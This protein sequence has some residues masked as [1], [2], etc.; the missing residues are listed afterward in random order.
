MKFTADILSKFLNIHPQDNILGFGIKGLNFALHFCLIAKTYGLCL[1]SN[2]KNRP[3]NPFVYLLVSVFLLASAAIIDIASINNYNQ[4]FRYIF[5]MIFFFPSFYI[6]STMFLNKKFPNKKEI[7]KI[8]FFVF[9]LGI[10][11]H[12]NIITF[13]GFL[14][15]IFIYSVF[16]NRNNLSL[17]FKNLFS[18]PVIIPTVFFLTGVCLS[19]FSESFL[20]YFLDERYPNKGVLLH[21]I[22]NFFAYTIGFI[23]FTF[24]K[25]LLAYPVLFFSTVSLLTFKTIQKKGDYRRIILAFGLIF[26]AIFFNYSLLACGRTYYDGYSYWFVSP[27]IIIITEYFFAMSLLLMFG[28]FV[29]TGKNKILLILLLPFCLICLLNSIPTFENN[30]NGSKERRRGMYETEK[31]TLFAIKNNHSLSVYPNNSPVCI[32]KWIIGFGAYDANFYLNYIKINEKDY[33][34]AEEKD[35]LKYYEKQGLVFSNEELQELNFTKL[36]NSGI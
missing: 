22:N 15:F 30:Y 7:P 12:F 28:E 13:I 10:S 27:D 1:N 9:L 6:V 5:N 21:V 34:C 23:K 20:H 2:L 36:R 24:L 19:F 26:G 3:L 31:A 33:R 17:Y 11:A 29:K 32:D 18:T 14:L 4:N 8:S 25:N 35:F 16:E